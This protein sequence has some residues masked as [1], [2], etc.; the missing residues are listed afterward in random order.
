MCLSGHREQ[1]IH[2]GDRF[3]SSLKNSREGTPGFGGGERRLSRY[4]KAGWNHHALSRHSL[5]APVS[6]LAF[7]SPHL[8]PLESR[9]WSSE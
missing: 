6:M 7:H 5:N 8:L 3:S 2:G 9:G 1:E 4:R